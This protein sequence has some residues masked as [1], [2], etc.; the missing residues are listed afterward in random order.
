[1]RLHSAKRYAALP[2]Q[3]FFGE[4]ALGESSERVEGCPLSTGPLVIKVVAMVTNPIG[5]PGG[6]PARSWISLRRD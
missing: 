2:G 3:P 5:I 1:M 4:A 6:E